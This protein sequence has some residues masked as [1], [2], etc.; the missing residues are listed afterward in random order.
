MP[1]KKRK[2]KQKVADPK[3]KIAWIGG[4]CLIIGAIGSPLVTALFKSS[5][6][7]ANSVSGTNINRA[8]FVSGNQTGN[9]AVDDHSQTARQT[10]SVGGDNFGSINANQYNSF[11]VDSNMVNKIASDLAILKAKTADIEALPDGRTVIGGVIATTKPRIILEKA[12]AGND[13]FVKGDYASAF[14]RFKEVIDYFENQKPAAGDYAVPAGAEYF[15][16]QVRAYCYG[17]AAQSALGLGSNS[18]ALGYAEK[19][20]KT[21][22]SA[23]NLLILSRCEMVLGVEQ[24]GN[25]N[26]EPGLA[27]LSQAV[28]SYE[29]AKNASGYVVGVMLVTNSNGMREVKVGGEAAMLAAGEVSRLYF[30]A[31]L[32][33][34]AQNRT[35]LAL[36]YSQKAVKS[37][38]SN[39]N[40][41]ALLQHIQ[42]LN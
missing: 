29:T 11:G 3:I 40:A 19:A 24:L 12:E 26:Y 42:G 16:A 31:G 20:V 15:S 32:A 30:F 5:P 10:I 21:D 28:D 1:P 13:S 6:S 17:M 22:S 27:F 36:D 2:P 41:V 33:A 4:I 25:K 9:N 39:T 8:V 35:A 23:R 37:D 34:F 14:A 7:P 18:L 38:A